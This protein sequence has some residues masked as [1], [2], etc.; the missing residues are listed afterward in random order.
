MIT[1]ESTPPSPE[2][3]ANAAQRHVAMG[4]GRDEGTAHT[5]R[6]PSRER[7]VAHKPPRTVAPSAA[8][9]LSLSS[10]HEFRL[11]KSVPGWTAQ[12]APW[13]SRLSQPHSPIHS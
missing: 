8:P 6:G 13:R 1:T 4:E 11:N 9:N 5:D 7:V 12:T 3:S 2:R 10:N